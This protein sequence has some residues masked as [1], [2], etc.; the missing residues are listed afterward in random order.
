MSGRGLDLGK[1]EGIFL[2]LLPGHRR[3]LFEGS[4]TFLRADISEAVFDRSGDLLEQ[5]DLLLVRLEGLVQAVVLL[6]SPDTQAVDIEHR[7][8]RVDH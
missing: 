2:N 1:I 8:I 7:F 3:W 6:T 4:C 5:L